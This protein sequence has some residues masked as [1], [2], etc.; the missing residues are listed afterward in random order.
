MIRSCHTAGIH[1]DMCE[2]VWNYAGAT[3]Q[4]CLDNAK[5]DGWAFTTTDLHGIES[6]SHRCP[7]CSRKESP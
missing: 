2:S 7:P 6:V 3:L 4:V 5:R 1:C